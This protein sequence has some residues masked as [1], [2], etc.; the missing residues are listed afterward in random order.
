MKKKLLLV[1]LG[2]LLNLSTYAD[3]PA[4]IRDEVYPWAQVEDEA[5]LVWID[6]RGGMIIFF[7]KVNYDDDCLHT[8]GL[9]TASSL[10]LGTYVKSSVAKSSKN[11]LNVVVG[12]E[13]YTGRTVMAQYSN[14]VEIQMIV[15][16][17]FFDFERESLVK[18]LAS[19]Q[20]FSVQFGSK[21]PLLKNIRH[22]G[23]S[24]ISKQL[25]RNCRR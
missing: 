1:L 13:E 11:E 2:W 17:G 23:Y 25:I 3:E 12:N 7:S 22:K 8:Y 10:K 6:D 5:R 16:D 19:N 9:I 21:D 24:N 15:E 20:S 4:Q 18:Q 14:G